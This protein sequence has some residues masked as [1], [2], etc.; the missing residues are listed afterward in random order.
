VYRETRTSQSVAV[1]LDLTVEQCTSNWQ[2]SASVGLSVAAWL[3]GVLTV[4]GLNVG[5]LRL[6]I[7]YTDG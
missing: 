1:Q 6:E 7:W 2:Q 5:K 3:H 4:L